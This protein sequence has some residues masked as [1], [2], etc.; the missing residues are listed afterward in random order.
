MNCEFYYETDDV[1]QCLEDYCNCDTTNYVNF[2]SQ[3]SDCV[4][5]HI[6][7]LAQQ[8]YSTEAT[9]LEPW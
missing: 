5:D 7:T 3:N 8:L 2:I 6:E 9:S 1:T 4:V